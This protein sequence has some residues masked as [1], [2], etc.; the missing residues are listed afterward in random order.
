[1]RRRNVIL[2]LGLLSRDATGLR[3]QTVLHYDRMAARIVEAL[4]PQPGERV[5]L[6]VDPSYFRELVA[7]LQKS[8]RARKAVVLRPARVDRPLPSLD[9]VDIYLWL[10]TKLE[11]SA[12]D[13]AALTEWLAKGGARREIHFHWSDGS[14]APDGLAG[15]HTAVLDAAYQEAIEV[16]SAE[17]SAAQDRFIQMLPKGTVRIY[18]PEGTDF[19]FRVGTRPFNKQD[20]NASAARALAARVKVD[21]E[22]ELPAGALRVAPVEETATGQIVL[23]EA[24]FGDVVAKNVKLYFDTGRI[25][26][27]TASE[28]LDAVKKALSAPGADQF[29]GF[30]LGFN[31]KLPGV[32]YYGYGAGVVRLSVG[33]NSELGGKVRGGFSRWFFFPNASIRLNET[34]VVRDGTFT[35]P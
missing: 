35:S 9:Q 27:I 14:R 12:A 20:G 33:D 7:P 8:L 15:Q 16:S 23:P 26:R 24:R 17:I 25:S 11:V 30:A 18:T 1:M 31:P 19:F 28:G 4:D 22:I 21:R 5:L 3:A 2:L 6:R 13:R 34:W 32:S 10:P 29:R